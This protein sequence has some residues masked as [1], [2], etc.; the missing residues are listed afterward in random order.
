MLG[1]RHQQFT[2]GPPQQGV[3]VAAGQQPC[4][5]RG[6]RGR[7]AQGGLVF[8]Q[9]PGRAQRRAHGQEF[10]RQVPHRLGGIGRANAGPGGERLCGAGAEHVQMAA[11]QRH[12]GLRWRQRGRVHHPYRGLAR[13]VPPQQHGAGGGGVSQAVVRHAQGLPDLAKRQGLMAQRR[14]HAGGGGVRTR[15]SPR[16]RGQ[17]PQGEDGVV[18]G[19]HSVDAESRP[20][21]LNEAGV[22][23]RQGR[24][25]RHPRM[26]GQ[27]GRAGHGILQ[28]RPGGGAQ[29]GGAQGHARVQRPRPAPEGQEL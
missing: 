27:Q 2:V 25:A 10:R 6:G 20:P 14:A 29:G 9:H 4:A 22:L 8:G 28:T 21:H 19:R 26:Q 1:V 24:D 11:C 15:L 17:A 16:I 7:C 5:G 12:A 18:D 23:P 13:T 3:G